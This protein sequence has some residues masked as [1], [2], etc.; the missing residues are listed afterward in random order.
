MK[1]QE[2]IALLSILSHVPILTDHRFGGDVA[3]L[4]VFTMLPYLALGRTAW[5]ECAPCLNLSSKSCSTH[6]P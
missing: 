5:R 2:M 4:V 6:E 3:T 1:A